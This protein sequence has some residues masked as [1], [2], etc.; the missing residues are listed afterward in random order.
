V[1]GTSNVKCDS[2]TII[3]AV[4]EI[5]PEVLIETIREFIN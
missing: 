4:T 5:I 2:E 1:T 3:N